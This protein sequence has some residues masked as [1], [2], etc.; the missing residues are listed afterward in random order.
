MNCVDDFD[1]KEVERETALLEDFIAT[2]LRVGSG[3][4]QRLSKVV[5]DLDHECALA[6]R[7]RER[8]KPQSDT[9]AQESSKSPAYSTATSAS[10]LVSSDV[11]RV[12]ESESGSRIS[13]SDE[14]KNYLVDRITAARLTEMFTPC[15]LLAIAAHCILLNEGFV[16]VAEQGSNV[17][18]FA[19]SVRGEKYI[20][21]SRPPTLLT[22]IPFPRC[23][24]QLTQPMLSRCYQSFRRAC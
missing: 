14:V 3:L 10:T 4:H 6:R 18:G 11:D 20:S 19:P 24:M 22:P 5:A 2:K 16:A 13:D 12:Y 1:L 8:S 17:P 15:T 9:S 23:S 7:K 21:W